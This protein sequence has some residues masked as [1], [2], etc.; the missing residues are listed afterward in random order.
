MIQER[1]EVWTR[2]HSSGGAKWA[3]SSNMQ[4]VKE[5][6]VR[7]WP[8]HRSKATQFASLIDICALVVYGAWRQK[9]CVFIGCGKAYW[10]TLGFNI[11][12]FFWL[13]DLVEVISFL[14]ASV[15]SPVKAE[16]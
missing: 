5:I 14:R 7:D 8:H 15:S 4:Q 2:R 13:P 6:L 9:V 11:F 3:G 12:S 16:P 10:K 1:G